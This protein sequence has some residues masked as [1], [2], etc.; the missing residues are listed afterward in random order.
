MNSNSSIHTDPD[1][2]DTVQL[3]INNFLETLFLDGDSIAFVFFAS[4]AAPRAPAR[5]ADR[6]A[7]NHF[8]A[9]AALVAVVVYRISRF[10]S[11]S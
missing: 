11:L 10:P 8:A 9:A 1:G 6:Q 5:P 2:K 4:S 3:N 7:D